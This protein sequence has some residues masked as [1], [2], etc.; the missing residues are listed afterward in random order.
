VFYFSTV[1]CIYG[2]WEHGKRG[3]KV[4]ERGKQVGK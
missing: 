2:R 4:K 1:K 3:R